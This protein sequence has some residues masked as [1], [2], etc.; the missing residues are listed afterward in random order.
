MTSDKTVRLIEAL[1]NSNFT[2]ETSQE[3]YVHY[4][5]LACPEGVLPEI[6]REI[7]EDKF[8]S[9]FHLKD[10]ITQRKSEAK[11]REHIEANK[12]KGDEKKKKK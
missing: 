7:E 6:L 9:I 4:A 10:T 8:P 3:E 5:K 12:A 11:A 2:I 1:R